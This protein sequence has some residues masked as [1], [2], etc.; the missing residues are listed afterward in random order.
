MKTAIMALVAVFVL[1]GGAA[2]Q[3][4]GRKVFEGKGLCHACH[5]RDATG[6]PLAP[7]LT[8][9]EWLNID[10]SL[11]AII[12]L[13]RTGVPKPLRHPAPMPPMGGARLSNTE[14]EAVAAYVK[15]LSTPK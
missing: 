8:D 14:I 4:T 13:V 12:A 9:S 3:E 6:T 1:V 10:G 7:D 11:A 2:A 5:G 15:G